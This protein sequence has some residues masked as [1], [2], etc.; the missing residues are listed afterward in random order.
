MVSVYD[1]DTNNDGFIN[2]KDLRRFY[3]F[4]IE[5]KNKKLLVPK[6]YSVT[7]SEY[8]P[9]N[10]FMYVFAQIDENRNG[11]R[12]DGEL[13]SVFWID[14]KSPHKNGIL[15]KNKVIKQTSL[16]Y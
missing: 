8:D 7:N 4:D 5:G 3:Y 16:L 9:E 11:S 10:D 12:D 15:Y 1:E 14:L 13:I 2:V 6:N